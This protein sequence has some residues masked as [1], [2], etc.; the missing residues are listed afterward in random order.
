MP[1]MRRVFLAVAASLAT[2]AA[3]LSSPAPASAETPTPVRH[4][5]KAPL[6][7][8]ECGTLSVPRDWF[9]RSNPDTFGIEYAVHRASE[10]R[11]GT[12]TLNPGG[13]GSGALDIAGLLMEVVPARIT[14]H[15]DIVLW[16][17]RGIGRSGPG[18]AHC[19]APAQ[20]PDM[21]ATGPVDWSAVATTYLRENS[22]ANIACYQANLG[23][24]PYLGTEYVVRD[25]DALRRALGVRKWTY[26]GMSYG[27][28]IGMVYARKYPTHLRAL[29]LDGSVAPNDSIAQLSAGMGASQQASLTV[30]AS[31]IGKET[32]ARLTR[33][34]RALNHR[35]YTD[36]DGITMTRWSF[37]SSVF[38][39]ARDNAELPDIIAMVNEA[40]DALFA[41]KAQS[42]TARAQAEPDFGRLYN[43]RFV[44]CADYAD[45][46]TAEQ[47]GAWAQGSV[48][49]GTMWAGHL[50]VHVPGWCAGLPAFAHP[51][52]RITRPIRL[53]HPPIVL[54]AMG[55]PG[56]PWVW[57]RQMATAFRGSSLITYAGT[58]HVL[59]GGTPSACVNDPVTTYLMTLRR[60]GDLTCPFTPG[61]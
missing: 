32:A 45:R 18:L 49:T 53:N 30:V 40:Y 59:Y 3:A 19:P 16:D 48:Q 9:D 42:A 15:F 43:T 41:S 56:T 2:V 37:L 36:A 54:N 61:R 35:T 11:V 44:N 46:P 29:L 25:L 10:H 58:A 4:A 22:A 21:P 20:M 8:W 38:A 51:V 52:P 14:R 26:W 33:V 31:L 24:A 47:V 7:D 5:C 57:A 23:I 28:R 12:L 27:T 39:L 34:I 55:D 50:T 6:T 13:P 17:P 60:P 1:P